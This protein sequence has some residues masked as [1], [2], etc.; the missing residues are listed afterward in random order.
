[1]LTLGSGFPGAGQA[2]AP[3]VRDGTVGPAG[4]VNAAG[5]VYTIPA[6]DGTSAGANLFHS[7]SNFNVPAATTVQFTDT[8]APSA[9][10][11]VI[12]RVTGS[13]Q[14]RIEG[15]LSNIPGA[16][17]YLLNPRGVFIG[18]NAFIDVS[19]SFHVSSGDYIRFGDGGRFYADPARVSTFSTAEPAAFGFL[20]GNPSGGTRGTIEVSGSPFDAG[21]GFGIHVIPD[22]QAWSFVG[23][24]VRIGWGDTQLAYLFSW[25]GRVNLV[26]VASAGEVQLTPTG[27]T[28]DGVSALGRV[29][30]VEGSSFDVRDIYIR[31]G[32]LNIDDSYLA[33]GVFTDTEGVIDVAVTG[34]ATIGG[35]GGFWEA[36]FFSAAGAEFGGFGPGAPIRLA[37]SGTLAVDGIGSVQT[38]NRSFGTENAGAVDI[39]A[40]TVEIRNGG[41][42][43]SRND[44][45]SGTGGALRIES[46][47]LRLSGDGP[48]S[49]SAPDFFA[50]DATPGI[51]AYT[52][53]GADAGSV[54]V[55]SSLLEVLGGAEVS[56]RTFG[57]GRG[58]DLTIDVTEVRVSRGG[59]AAGGIAAESIGT[60]PGGGVIPTGDAGNLVIRAARLSLLD[61]NAQ[62][63][64]STNSTGRAG[65]VTITA[66]ESVT[67]AGRNSGVFSSTRGK[68]A[69]IG[70][71]PGDAGNVAITTPL[72]RMDGPGRIE[73]ATSGDGSAG[74]VLLDVGRL[75]LLGGAQ[76]RSF[77]GQ[78]LPGASAP[79]VGLGNAGTVSV[80]ASE[81]ASLSGVSET[82]APT[83]L[84]SQTRGPGAG[85]QVEVYTPLLTLADG[86][87]IGADTGG[88]GDAGAVYV[89]VD[90][91]TLSGGARISS[92]SGITVGGLDLLGTGE[93][94]G[95]TLVARESASL[96]GSGTRVSTR[97]QGAG[98]G[99]VVT[100]QAGAIDLAGGAVI[101]SDT[102]GTGD[103]G[104]VLLYGDT[105]R[106]SGSGTRVSTETRGTGAGGGVL[107]AGP[108]LQ[109]QGG[110]VV[111]AETFGTGNAGA[112]VLEG[113][114]VALAG[115]GTRVSTG[116][117]GPGRGGDVE[118]SGEQLSITSGASVSASSTGTGLAGNIT[119]RLG[120]SLTMQGGSVTTQAV[121]SDGGNITITAPR[122]IHLRDS[123]ITT[124]VESGTGGGGNIFIDPQFVVLQNSQ[125]IA[126]AFGGPG[127]NIR[128]VA[129]QLIA[130]P[131][132]LISASS[133]L[134]IDGT[135]N[136]DA[137][138]TNVSSALVALPESY[139]D[140]SSLL[141]P[142]CGAARAGLSSLVEVG[143]GGLP[144]DPDGYL[145]SVDVDTKTV[146]PASRRTAARAAANPFEGA[147]AFAGQGCRR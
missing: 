67:T 116:T 42:V 137:P 66:T 50:F 112:V 74:S 134:G 68:A 110:A 84:S 18:E 101:A 139:L 141:Q 81:S 55:T 75:E 5:G 106:L 126:N 64:A 46:Q 47:T 144:P 136:I 38:L 121:T 45:G 12:S 100:L 98:S 131:S 135:V 72:L 57:A 44:A 88:D 34:D 123:Q 17:F 145:W 105:T 102:S 117:S 35:A 22:G 10:A 93:G 40:G 85:G 20:G 83:S 39:V 78:V 43:V 19:G 87:L 7:F 128:I 73:A 70:A 9:V 16:N 63:S 52:T 90:R 69:E 21:F 48:R 27:V 129:G 118:I 130:D 89:E 103:A 132:T 71:Q 115:S 36:G 8:G 29:D 120:D 127:G 91:A 49:A 104:A 31:A 113:G 138:D 95:V 79:D 82:G 3:I 143:R 80:R 54:S 4:P 62:V 30:I 37:V 92:D 14:T 53:N 26:S 33:S 119:I 61:D 94:G 133:A 114:N 107:I 24:D 146:A 59:A 2:Q 124:S 1:M 76:V 86:A 28:L 125:I 147:L 11:N 77:S 56:A 6:S 60:Q 99:G 65:A 108:S 25:A 51:A 13:N 32:T 109:L 140:A 122:L 96:S 15:T 142:S 58:G 111:S 97:T 41:F 23:G